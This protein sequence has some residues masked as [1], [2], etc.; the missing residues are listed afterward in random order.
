[1]IRL[2]LAILLLPTICWAGPVQDAQRAVIT[3]MQAGGGGCET[4]TTAI[5]QTVNEENGL[6]LSTTTGTVGQSLTVGTQFVLCSISL[7]TFQGSGKSATL[8]IGTSADLSTYTEEITATIDASED[9]VFESTTNP[10]IATGTWYFAV[11]GND[12]DPFYPRR[13]IASEYG[14]GAYLYTTTVGSWNVATSLT[15]DLYF[16]VSE[17]D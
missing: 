7:K 2:I 13:T 8:R 16:V 3:A 15:K 12:V 4:C 5:S 17:C 10:T 14:G 11:R 1:M 6:G 9:V